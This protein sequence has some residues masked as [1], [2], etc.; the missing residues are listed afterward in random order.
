MQPLVRM[1]AKILRLLGYLAR[2]STAKQRS[3]R[4]WHPGAP[5]FRYRPIQ[6]TLPA[7]FLIRRRRKTSRPLPKPHTIAMSLGSSEPFR[8]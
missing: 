6:R 5:A 1:V 4:I 2:N 7:G 8:E 3:S